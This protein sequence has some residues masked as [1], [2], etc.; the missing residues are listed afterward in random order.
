MSYDRVELFKETDDNWYPSYTL[1]GFKQKLVQVAFHG[2]ISP[3]NE[4]KVYRV[5]VWGADDIGME[6]DC[7]RAGE[8]WSMFVRVINMKKV[9]VAELKQMGFVHA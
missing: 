9:N 2:N 3:P 8:S 5:S 1:E 6:Y 4:P 7:S